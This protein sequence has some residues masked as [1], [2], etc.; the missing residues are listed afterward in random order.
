M[1][2]MR[3]RIVGGAIVLAVALPVAPASAAFPGKNGDIAFGRSSRGQVDIWVV[4]PGGTGTARLTR[5]PRKIESMPDWSADGARVVFVRC[6]PAVFGNCDIYTMAADGTEVVRL[7]ATADVQETWPA[8]SPDG[9]RIAYTS[10]ASD[11]FQDIWVMDA[12]GS[13]QTQLTTTPGFDAFP[14]WSPDGSRIAFS[15]DRRALD[16]IWVMDPDGS[17]PVRLT[18]GTNVDERPDWSPDGTRIVFGR[19]GDVWVMDADGRNETALTRTAHDDFAP[20]YSPNGRRIA[21]NRRSRDERIGVWVMRADG[22]RRVQRTFGRIDF[23]P[24]WQ[25]FAG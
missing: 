2:S 3:S 17:N 7:T 25:P 11:G 6:A 16:D 24:D 13:G 4:G 5:T 12:D 20:A 8:W 21:F 19:G 1:R 10:D 18:H 22:T 23:F 14:E 15:S 9:S